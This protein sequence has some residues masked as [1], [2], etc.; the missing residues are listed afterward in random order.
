MVSLHLRGF[1]F[2]FLGYLIKKIT[3]KFVKMLPT[4]NFVQWTHLPLSKHLFLIN[5]F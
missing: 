3:T 4:L 1:D 5:S 2:I